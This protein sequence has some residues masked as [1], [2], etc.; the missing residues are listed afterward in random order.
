[1]VFQLFYGKP[2]TPV[3]Y[4]RAVNASDLSEKERVQAYSLYLHATVGKGM[5]PADAIQYT[6]MIL[7][8]HRYDHLEY[9]TTNSIHS[10]TA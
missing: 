7:M 3:E 10:V 4:N 6:M 8:K 1:M 2:D 5:R 9:D